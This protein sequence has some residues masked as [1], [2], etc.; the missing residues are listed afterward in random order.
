MLKA[1]QINEAVTLLKNGEIIAIPTETVYGLAADATNDEAL[2]KIFAA[3]NRPLGHPLIVHIESFDKVTDWAE[4]IPKNAEILAKEFWPGPITMIFQKRKTVSDLITGG[5][6]TVALRVPNHPIALEIIRKLKKGLAAPSANTHKK[7]SPTKPEHVLKKLKGKIAAVLDG[8]VCGVGI[9]STIIDITKETPIILR[10]G[11][12][13]ANA[14]EK[15]LNTKVDQPFNH[16]EK[17]SGN[18]NVHYQPNKPLLVLPKKELELKLKSE[19]NIAI[20]H[21]SIIENLSSAKLYQMPTTKAE[22]AKKLYEILHHVDETNVRKI[23]VEEPPTSN[24]WDC[25]N[26]RLKRASS[27]H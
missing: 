25:I 23:F 19:K 11:A 26:D 15:A 27:K 17:V 9:E 5:L 4:H 10:P 12:V 21:H 24:D 2:R 7:L 18:M 13:T 1:D 16:C 14:I 3:K 8:G 22:Y 6:D 20:I